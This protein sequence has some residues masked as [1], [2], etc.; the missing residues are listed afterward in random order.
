MQ[1]KFIA[2]APVEELLFTFPVLD[3]FLLSSLSLIGLNWK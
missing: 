2:P 3:L 1:A